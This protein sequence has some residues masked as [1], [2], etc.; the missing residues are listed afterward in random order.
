MEGQILKVTSRSIRCLMTIGFEKKKVLFKK[1]CQPETYVCDEPVYVQIPS[2][3]TNRSI[4]FSNGSHENRVR[5]SF[6]FVQWKDEAF[7]LINEYKV[8]DGFGCVVSWVR[9]DRGRRLEYLRA[10]DNISPDP[11]FL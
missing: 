4:G 7:C 8:L 2:G 3:G 9:S 1:S 10:L 5:E 11:V 6:L